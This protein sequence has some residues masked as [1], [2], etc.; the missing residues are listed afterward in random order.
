MWKVLIFERRV[1]FQTKMLAKAGPSG[2]PIATPSVCLYMILLK[3]NSIPNVALFMTSMKT[4]LEI[5]GCASEPMQYKASAKMLIVS[6]SGA[7]IKRLELSN[8]NTK[9]IIESFKL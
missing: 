1:F 5:N 9:L 4:A 6:S 7:F 3:L 8:E 2:E